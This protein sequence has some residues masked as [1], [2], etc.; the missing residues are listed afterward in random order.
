MTHTYLVLLPISHL[1]PRMPVAGCPPVMNPSSTPCQ[2]TLSA[3]D[4]D[5]RIDVV[6]A[7]RLAAQPPTPSYLWSDEAP[8]RHRCDAQR[9]VPTVPPV[10]GT[11]ANNSFLAVTPSA[12]RGPGG[13]E[14]V[15]CQNLAIG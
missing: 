11:F 10:V 4:S 13:K 3:V 6:G 2:P 12:T 15:P 7:A 9:K 8:R 5:A 1:S 14:R